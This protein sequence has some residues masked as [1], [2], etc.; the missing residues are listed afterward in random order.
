MKP[1]LRYLLYAGTVAVSAAVLIFL[2]K[3]NDQRRSQLTCQSV[4]VEVIDSAAG[5]FVTA[6]DIKEFIESSTGAMIGRN[7]DS[8]ELW[9]IEELLLGK[10]AVLESQAYIC[11]DGVL[12]V[13]VLQRKP[14][15]RFYGTD[16]S[17]YADATGYT[18]PI[19]RKYSIH[20]PIIDGVLPADEDHKWMKGM[21][22]LLKYI[23]DHKVWRKGISQITASAD[24]SLILTPATGQ[25]KFI[26]GYP[27][28][29]KEKFQKIEKYYRYI[30]P[31]SENKNYTTV[32]VRYKGQIIC[33]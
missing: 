5:T 8:L 2:N 20:L 16:R 24:G 31:S 3:E 23:E 33:K 32:N 14:I 17:F 19:N 6:K 7:I 1:V 15:A 11:D 27:E 21:I 26:F 13:E 28:R 4:K 30:A 29:W 10:A 25:E 18:F 22:G 12:H 9:R